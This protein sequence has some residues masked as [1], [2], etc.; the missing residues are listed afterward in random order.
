MGAFDDDEQAHRRRRDVDVESVPVHAD[1]RRLALGSDRGLEPH[2]AAHGRSVEAPAVGLRHRADCIRTSA[3]CRARTTATTPCRIATAS[4]VARIR[5]R[6]RARAAPATRA[7]IIR[8][9]PRRCSTPARRR[10]SPRAASRRRARTRPRVRA[11][12]WA[13]RRA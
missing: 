5:P 13:S 7:S 2:H 6:G 9:A 8:I 11:I 10:R 1:A 4:W 3:R 12:S